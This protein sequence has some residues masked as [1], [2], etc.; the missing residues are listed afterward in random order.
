MDRG[1]HADLAARER[2][3]KTRVVAMPR[4]VPEAFAASE[5]E[6]NVYYARISLLFFLVACGGGSSRD[7]FADEAP[8][9][10]GAVAAPSPLPGPPGAFSGPKATPP[11]P[12]PPPPPITVVYGHSATTLYQLD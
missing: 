9:P 7:G 11:P 4:C 2:R 5:V 3:C 1:Y 10:A 8:N 12:A 6:V